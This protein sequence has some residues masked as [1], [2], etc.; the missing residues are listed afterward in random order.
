MGDEQKI[1]D[2]WGCSY[3]ESEVELYPLQ[4]WYNQLIDK[5]VSEIEVSDVLRMIRQNEFIDIAIQRAVKFL[6]ENPFAGEM[7]EG[8]LLEKMSTLE[9]GALKQ[10]IQELREVLGVALIKNKTYEWLDEEERKDFEKVIGYFLDKI[11]AD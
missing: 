3:I 9:R 8:E 2:I 5:K 7:Y 10:Y 6:K 11:T 1:K 4:K